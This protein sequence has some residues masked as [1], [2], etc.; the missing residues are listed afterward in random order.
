MIRLVTAFLMLCLSLSAQAAKNPGESAQHC[1][2]AIVSGDTLTLKNICS[3]KLF[4]LYCG[5][6]K[7]SNR[8]CGSG[9]HGEYYTH[10]SNLNVGEESSIKI[11]GRYQYASCKGNISFG[12][13]GE[14][15]DFSDGSFE[16]LKR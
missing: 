13:D 5:D 6:L 7:Y 1:V 10:S 9:K 15:K 2:T 4:V 3:E 14:Y 16:C 8:K 11:N 12:N